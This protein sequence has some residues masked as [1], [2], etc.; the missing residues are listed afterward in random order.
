MKCAITN[1]SNKLCQYRN[2]VFTGQVI[3]SGTNNRPA[4][5]WTHA[6]IVRSKSKIG[7]TNNLIVCGREGRKRNDQ[8]RL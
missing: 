8:N 6:V 3:L 4:V 5:V 1:K 7:K 2:T